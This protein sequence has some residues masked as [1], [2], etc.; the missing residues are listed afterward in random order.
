MAGPSYRD[1]KRLVEFLLGRLEDRLSGRDEPVTLKVP[2]SD[3]C[4]LGVLA[5]WSVEHELDDQPTEQVEEE[6]SSGVETSSIVERSSHT[7]LVEEIVKTDH[8]SEDRRPLEPF[9]SR[10]D[11]GRRPRPR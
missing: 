2:P 1:E 8:D 7:D 4:Q 5:P 6:T 10:E 11:A 9:S 3:H